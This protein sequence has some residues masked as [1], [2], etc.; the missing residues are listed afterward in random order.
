MSLFTFDP[1]IGPSPGVGH[2]REVKLLEAEFGEG[3]SQ[4]TPKGLNHIRKSLDL[5]WEALTLSQRDEIEDFLIDHKGN[6]P[7]YYRPYGERFALKWTCKEWS[8]TPDGGVWV[9]SATFVQ[10]FTLET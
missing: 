3:Y 9:F 5:K 2:G 7:F 4:S 8:S 6:T 10:S 1:P